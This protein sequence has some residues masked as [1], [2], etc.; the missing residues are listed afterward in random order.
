MQCTQAQA[1]QSL[2]IDQLEEQQDDMRAQHSNHFAIKNL[3]DIMERK[4]H[5]T[6]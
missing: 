6:R 1:G 2:L 3:D 5:M 4:A